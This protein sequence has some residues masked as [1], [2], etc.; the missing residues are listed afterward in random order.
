MPSTRHNTFHF[1]VKRLLQNLPIAIAAIVLILTFSY[2]ASAYTLLGGTSAG[3]LFFTLLFIL[4]ARLKFS[5]LST[6]ALIAY[7]WLLSLIKKIF[8]KEKLFFS[9]F[10]VLLD[11]NNF[12]TVAHYPLPAAV[13]L[14]VTILLGFLL[15]RAFKAETPTVL[16]FSK[17]TL[18]GLPVMAVC[19]G[20]TV[21]SVAK[22]QAAWLNSM[23]KGSNVVANLIM[24][25]KLQYNSPAA[26][27]HSDE[28]FPVETEKA[29]DKTQA[30][31]D[32]VVLL[33]ESTTNP[34]YFK[35][36]DT[37]TLPD[38]SMF[39]SPTATVQ[40]PLRVHTYGGATWK[41]EFSM[42]TGLSCDD[43]A[44]LANSVFY[45]A[46]F[47]VQDS[48]FQRLKNA[49][50]KIV[51]VSPFQPGSYNSGKAYAH[52]G[53][54]EQLHPADLGYP[55]ER[56]KNL[57]HIKTASM[58]EMIKKAL[59]RYEGPI[60]IY[61]LT[62]REHGPYPTEGSETLNIKT[63]N[64]FDVPDNERV[65]LQNYFNR[66]DESSAAVA[67]FD[68]WIHERNKPTVLLRFG[69]HQPALKWS[70]GYT[71]PFESPE[72]ITHFTLVDNRSQ[73]HVTRS[74]LMDIVFL[75]S[76]LLD[77]VPIEKGR[78]FETNSRMRELCDGRYLD[79]P[80]T[81]LLKAYQNEI[82]VNQRIAE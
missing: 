51:V 7:I 18:I 45:S 43:F 68:R 37:S 53:M 49:G 46:V 23:P 10:E 38:M 25:A 55:A 63:Q 67:A 59:D 4:S 54:D 20:L 33:Q 50:Y 29:L 44:P 56:R 32:V 14:F 61:S 28:V 48:L 9:D 11:P 70:P 21:F 58:I 76:L 36:L 30:L 42:W 24:S 6:S 26:V 35:G 73:E 72:Y 64:G 71:V 2:R 13:V 40:G 82:F 69:D 66:I 57:W 12:E 78:F 79:C 77:H 65:T 80:D 17:R 15:V 41:S 1:S 47:H 22:G 31:P 52:L 16:N 60:A 39:D 75:P 5:L 19:A 8:W 34:L 62:M 74:Q 81:R 27:M 3:F